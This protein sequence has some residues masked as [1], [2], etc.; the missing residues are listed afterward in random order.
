MLPAE[1]SNSPL[2]MAEEDG[3]P[4]SDIK[5]VDALADRIKGRKKQC[6]R[7]VGTLVVE[8]KLITFETHA[9]FGGLD[10]K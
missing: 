7:M 1:N 8:I 4:A 10:K 3:G 2:N 5:S 9:D 6:S